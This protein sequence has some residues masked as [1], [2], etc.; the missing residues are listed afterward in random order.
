MAPK[1]YMSAEK[2]ARLF[3]RAEEGRK[4]LKGARTIHQF[5]TDRKKANCKVCK[6]PQHIKDQINVARLS[7]TFSMSVVKDWLEEEFGITGIPLIDFRR[8]YSA[9]HEGEDGIIYR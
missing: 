5:M 3:K 4:K 6:I 9:A 2:R 1:S 8:H 7:R